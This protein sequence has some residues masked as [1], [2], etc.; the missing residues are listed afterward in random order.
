MRFFFDQFKR[1]CSE[2]FKYQD[3]VPTKTYKEINK[4]FLDLSDY[5]ERKRQTQTNED[6][7]KNL[8]GKNQDLINEISAVDKVENKNKDLK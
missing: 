3:K 5:L 8:T 4:E 2:L 7:N 1:V 6:P